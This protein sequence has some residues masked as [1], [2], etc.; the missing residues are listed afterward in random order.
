MR[1]ERIKAISEEYWFGQYARAVDRSLDLSTLEKRLPP[2][3][4]LLCKQLSSGY[5]ASELVELCDSSLAREVTRI[6]KDRVDS[7]DSV[8]RTSD[9]SGETLAR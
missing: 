4:D 7:D 5:I 3:P 9:P 6:R 8:V 1:T 2:E